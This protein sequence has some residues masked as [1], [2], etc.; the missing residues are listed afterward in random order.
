MGGIHYPL[1]SDFWPHGSVS[2]LYGVL[3]SDGKSERAIFIIDR[4]GYIQYIDIHEIDEQPSND[5]LFSELAKLNPYIENT[6]VAK[7]NPEVATLPHGG[8][9]MYCTSWCPG[10]RRAKVWLKNNNIPFTEVDIN[11]FPGAGDQLKKWTGGY[12]TTPTF[13][14]DGTI[15]IDYNEEKLAAILKPKK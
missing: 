3:R 13:D 9:V 7:V 2:E 1:L 12:L 10:C 4:R 6:L 5:V 14:I 8:V 11:S 15:L